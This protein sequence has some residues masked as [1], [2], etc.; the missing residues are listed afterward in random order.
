MRRALLAAAGIL[1]VVLVAAQLLLPGVAEDR[2]RS[3]LNE[4][5]TEAEVEIKAL[6]AIKLLWGHADDVT[7][8]VANLRT[9]EDGGDDG[10]SL[11][12]LLAQTS[13][14]KQLDVHVKVLEDKLL[15][16]QD[17]G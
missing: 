3:D 4:Q 7:I 12:D 17:V 9:D 14:T 5:G 15:R 2:V 13:K 1:V 6:P 10:D 11:S 8:E 16:M